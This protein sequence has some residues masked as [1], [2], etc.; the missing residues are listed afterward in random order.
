MEDTTRL[1]ELRRMIRGCEVQND[2]ILNAFKI[3]L[4]VLG[5]NDVG[6]N[7]SDHAASFGPQG[8]T[9]CRGRSSWFA[10]LPRL[11]LKP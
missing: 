7:S 5:P 8:M 4:R 3:D 9:A 6:P 2:L 10:A 1:P 11:A